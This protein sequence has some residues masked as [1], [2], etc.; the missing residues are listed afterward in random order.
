MTALLTVVAH[1]YPNS[2]LTKL[3]L[4]HVLKGYLGS[5]WAD[6]KDDLLVIAAGSAAELGNFAFPCGDVDI[7]MSYRN[8][9]AVLTISRGTASTVDILEIV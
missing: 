5:T 4:L 2:T 8:L 3:I 9:I 6:E 1:K 7:M